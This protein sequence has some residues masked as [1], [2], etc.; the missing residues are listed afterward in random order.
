MAFDEQLATR[1]RAGLGSRSG[2]AEKKMF[3]GLAFLFE[4][5]MFCG[6]VGRDLMVRVGPEASEECLALDHVRPM[7]FTGRP[8][9]GYVFVALP[10]LQTAESLQ[11]WVDR[12]LE[13]VAGA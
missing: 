9:K 6:I 4:G 13:C 5:R 8:M 12:G 1:I 10:G 3:G 7:D 11:Q 2:I